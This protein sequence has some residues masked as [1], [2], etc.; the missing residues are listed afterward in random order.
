[1]GGVIERITIEVTGATGG[2]GVA[3]ANAISDTPIEGTIRAIYLAYVGSP[4]AGTTDVVI[5]EA[6][7]SPAIVAITVTNGA[8]DGWR[9]LLAQAVSNA[10]A[11][12]TNQGA[13]VVVNDYIRA[14]IS[15]AN[16]DDGL[17]V[18]IVYER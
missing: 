11:S 3:T 8:T 1:M 5:A 4:P 14:T 7:N 10:D 17:T 6:Y 18:T 15:Q 16:N 12:I 2:V 9:F 13:P